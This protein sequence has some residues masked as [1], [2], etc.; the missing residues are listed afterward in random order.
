MFVK[1]DMDLAANQ[2]GQ[3]R[4][5]SAVRYMLHADASH[6]LEQLASDMSDRSVAG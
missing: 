3:R 2:V 5:G 1:H 6:H 4:R